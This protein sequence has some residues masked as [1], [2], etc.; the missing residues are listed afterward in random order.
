MHSGPVC[1]HPNWW[2]WTGGDIDFKRGIIHVRRATTQASKGK[3]EKTKTSAGT[4][5]VKMLPLAKAALEAQK[6]W[7]FLKGG[8]VFQNPRTGNRWQGDQP[9][10]KTMWVHA[11]KK[12]EVRYRYP[13]QTRHTYASMMLSAGEH[14]M[15]VASQMG[16]EDWG[17][18]RKRYGKWMPDAAPNA[19][20]AADALFGS[21]PGNRTAQNLE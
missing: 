12:A 15:W 18:I 9:I 6:A 17:L 8:E 1:A 14:P 13:Y 3:A 16:H 21:G 19:G 20:S 11:L 2:P 5:E 7:T 10:R 4:R